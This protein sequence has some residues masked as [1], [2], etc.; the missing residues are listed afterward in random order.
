MDGMASL[1]KVRANKGGAG[2]D[3]M[4]WKRWIKIVNPCS[5]SYG[6]VSPRAVTFLHP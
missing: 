3:E 4:D 5:I 2:I 6:T 1:R